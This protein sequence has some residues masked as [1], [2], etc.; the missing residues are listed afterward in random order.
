MLSAVFFL[1][2]CK[3]QRSAQSDVAKEIESDSVRVEYRVEYIPDT[4][5][6]ALPHIHDAVSTHD[7]TSTLENDYA[8]S[9]A[10][11]VDGFLYHTLDTKQQNIQVPTQRE[12]KYIDRYVSKMHSKDRI[13]TVTKMKYR[14]PL[15]VI[16]Y[17]SFVTVIIVAFLIWVIVRTINRQCRQNVI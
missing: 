12:V 16:I 14:I 3:S 9:Y 11:I 5:Y 13:V 7:S 2:A 4:V 1:S 8:Y 15:W 10:A 17:S 6:F